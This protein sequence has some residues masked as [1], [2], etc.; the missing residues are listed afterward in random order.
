MNALLRHRQQCPAVQFGTQRSRS[1]FTLIELLV[2]ISIIV[3]LIAILMPSL[4]K[5]RDAAKNTQCFNALRGL[6]VGFNT[7]AA[8]NKDL[9]PPPSTTTSS[10]GPFW[11]D[12]LDPYMGTGKNKSLLYCPMEQVHHPSMVDYGVNVPTAFYYDG[13]NRPG[14]HRLSLFK[15]PSELIAVGDSRESTSGYW[16]TFRG[17]WK[18]DSGALDVGAGVYRNWGALPFPPRHNGNM[19][20]MWMDAHVNTIKMPDRPTAELKAM[21]LVN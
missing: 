12:Y 4:K 3:L 16:E 21:F 19:N 20:F 8:D 9:L 10:T 5:A 18:I 17:S 1:G 2:V 13:S 11:F 15:R 7:Y 6:G 14:S